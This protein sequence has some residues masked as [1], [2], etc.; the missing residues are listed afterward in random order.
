MWKKIPCR[1]VLLSY[2][3]AVGP[4]EAPVEAGS[5]VVVG[6]ICLCNKCSQEPSSSYS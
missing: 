5:S 3:G 6:F 4:D 2:G 1:V